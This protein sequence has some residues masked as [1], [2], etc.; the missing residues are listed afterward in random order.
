MKHIWLANKIDSIYFSYSWFNFE[1]NAFR[2]DSF[3]LRN[4]FYDGVAKSFCKT[5]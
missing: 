3:C 1:E 2:C 5:T 4:F